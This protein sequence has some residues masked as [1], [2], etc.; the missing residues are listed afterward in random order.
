[1]Q[2]GINGMQPNNRDEIQLDNDMEHN[3]IHRDT[4]EFL[5]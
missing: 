5:K 3:Q 1:M 4:S 2:L